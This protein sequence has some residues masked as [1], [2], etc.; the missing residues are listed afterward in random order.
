MKHL[1]HRWPKPTAGHT[2]YPRIHY[3]IGLACSCGFCRSPV[4][5]LQRQ[6]TNICSTRTARI[7]LHHLPYLSCIPFYKR[8]WPFPVWY[9]VAAFSSGTVGI[10]NIK[11]LL[12]SQLILY[13]ALVD[14]FI[15]VLNASGSLLCLMHL[16]WVSPPSCWQE[17]FLWMPYVSILLPWSGERTITVNNR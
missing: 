12:G 3:G 2:M 13:C 15:T 7:A 1:I 9:T 10:L 6:N 14:I 5:S 8:L 17:V 16:H 11:A 4:W